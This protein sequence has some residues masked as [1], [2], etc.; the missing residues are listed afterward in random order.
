MCVITVCTVYMGSWFLFRTIKCPDAFKLS[1][2][3]TNGVI[4]INHCYT[5]LD[6]SDLMFN[7]KPSVF[8][9]KKDVKTLFCLTLILRH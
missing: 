9:F 4:M 7:K 6:L 8:V 1:Y 2:I 3:N 5:Y